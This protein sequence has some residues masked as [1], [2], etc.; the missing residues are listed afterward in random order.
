MDTQAMRTK[1]DRDAQQRSPGRGGRAPAGVPGAA[2]ALNRAIGNRAFASLAREV[3]YLD[4][5][6]QLEKNPDRWGKAKPGAQARARP[7]LGRD[8]LDSLPSALKEVLERSWAEAGAFSHYRAL[9]DESR[10][11]LIAWYNRMIAYELRGTS[12]PS[13]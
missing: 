3:V 8:E 7:A 10:A 13:R 2:A 12:A 6:T 9:S 4:P 1:V 5:R 11:F